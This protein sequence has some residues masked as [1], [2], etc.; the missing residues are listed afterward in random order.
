MRGWIRENFPQ[1]ELAPQFLHTTHIIK[2]WF[3]QHDGRFLGY[4]NNK[5]V[6]LYRWKDD[7]G[8]FEQ[9][10]HADPEFLALLTTRMLEGIY[11][12]ARNVQSMC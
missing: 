8:D 1:V 2:Y 10:N 6:F 11:T 7:V 5:G 3:I 12:G 9:L 4:L